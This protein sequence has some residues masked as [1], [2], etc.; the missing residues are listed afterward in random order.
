LLFIEENQPNLDETKLVLS[1]YPTSNSQY[2]YDSHAHPTYLDDELLHQFDEVESSWYSS[3]LGKI[4][5]LVVKFKINVDMASEFGCSTGRL[6]F[7]LSKKF[8]EVCG[9]DF[10]GRFLEVAMRLQI[11]GHFEVKLEKQNRTIKF[12]ITDNSN[13]ANVVFK[14][15]TWIPNEIPK[16]DLVVFSMIDRVV[17]VKC[18]DIFIFI[19]VFE[20]K[21]KLERSFL[22]L[23]FIYF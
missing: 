21:T 16:S 5:E 8:N 9:V 15:M 23:C 7:D 20:N 22:I 6:C 18:K 1:Y 17:S 2:L 12:D 13:A 14:Q 4:L 10:C 3:F 11:D 19:Y